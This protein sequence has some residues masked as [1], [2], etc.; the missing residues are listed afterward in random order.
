MARF[1]AQFRSKTKEVAGMPILREFGG[2]EPSAPSYRFE[3][4]KFS[5]RDGI[6]AIRKAHKMAK[7]K[8]MVL[9]AVIMTVWH[10]HDAVA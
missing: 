3:S 4:A 7:K 8:D 5:A 10:K 2:T 1:E 9:R 6:Q